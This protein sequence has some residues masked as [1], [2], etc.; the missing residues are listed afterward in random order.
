MNEMKWKHSKPWRLHEEFFQYITVILRTVQYDHL[1]W[2][3]CR[4]L[5]WRNNVTSGKRSGDETGMQHLTTM[6]HTKQL[7]ISVHSEGC[8]TENI[9]QLPPQKV[10]HRSFYGNHS[11]L[12]M[13][14]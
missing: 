10:I 13:E 14:I 4:I 9:E 8:E 5:T 6:H 7:Y 12:R 1:A 2:L 3:H 11:C